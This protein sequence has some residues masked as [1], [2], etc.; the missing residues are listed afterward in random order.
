MG[1]RMPTI[2]SSVGSQLTLAYDTSE[3]NYDRAGIVTI[4]RFL[5][6]SLS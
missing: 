3:E 6:G 4:I 5:N 1:L 2:A